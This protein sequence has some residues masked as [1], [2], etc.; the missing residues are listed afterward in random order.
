MKKPLCTIPGCNR[1]QQ[2]KTAGLC[3]RCY[4]RQWYQSEVVGRADAVTRIDLT[5]RSIL[6]DTLDTV[7]RQPEHAKTGALRVNKTAEVPNA[8][9]MIEVKIYP[10]LI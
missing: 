10:K 8:D 4:A 3:R 7:R 1:V 5:L 6:E 2:Y 9:Y